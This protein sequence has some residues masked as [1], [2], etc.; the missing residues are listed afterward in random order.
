M[1]DTKEKRSVVLT[2]GKIC[3]SELRDEQDE[4]GS[5]PHLCTGCNNPTAWASS[6]RRCRILSR[7]AVMTGFRR[8]HFILRTLPVSFAKKLFDKVS[9]AP[10]SPSSEVRVFSMCATTAE[11]GFGPVLIASCVDDCVNLRLA[12]AHT[13]N[14]PLFMLSSVWKIWNLS[15][16]TLV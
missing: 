16:T 8:L 9:R 10:T 5:N 3:V 7:W 15:H 1:M 12:L 13:R 2:W 14:F 6:N 4:S 11:A